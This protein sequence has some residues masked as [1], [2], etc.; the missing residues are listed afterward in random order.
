MESNNQEKSTTLSNNLS[1]ATNV[2]L[3]EIEKKEEAMRKSRRRFKLIVYTIMGIA[4]F[5]VL[6][7]LVIMLVQYIQEKNK[8][9]FEKT[10]VEEQKQLLDISKN[11]ATYDSNEIRVGIK[12]PDN[13]KLIENKSYEGRV[14]NVEM[15]YTPTDKATVTG[16]NLTEGFIFRIT[17]LQIS[18]KN[19]DVVASV[20]RDSFYAECGENVQMSAVR[21]DVVN[22]LEARTFDVR[23]CNGDF[24]VTY[25]SKFGI[26]YELVQLYRGDLGFIQQYKITTEEMMKSLAFHPDDIIV[27]PPF[28]EYQDV[29]SDVSFTYPKELSADCCSVPEPNT[30]T[31]NIVT[32]GIKETEEKYAAF[33]IFY[34]SKR[35]TS[36]REDRTFDEYVQQQKEA[37]IADYKIVNDGREPTLIEEQLNVN[38]LF[39]VRFKGLSW[40]GNDVILVNVTTD[41]RHNY[42]YSIS[43]M[44]KLGPDFE[45]TLKDILGTMS[46]EEI[47]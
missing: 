13:A 33:G 23:N 47:E 38:G 12:Y 20:K 14:R 39:A 18:K 4:A 43:V 1:S 10:P 44:N 37:L 26:Y 16:N 9:S 19:L 31:R 24:K 5:I 2:I 34:E 36:G 8:K 30:R 45:T 42:F 41:T 3:P 11:W 7:T 40:K 22:D 17:P 25:T 32:M 15:I 29:Q 27:E 35:L 46:F 28:K 6:S 21:A